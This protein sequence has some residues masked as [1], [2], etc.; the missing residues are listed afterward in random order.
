[1][2]LSFEDPDD[3]FHFSLS[4]DEGMYFLALYLALVNAVKP[5]YSE[6]PVL[7]ARSFL[8]RKETSLSPSTTFSTSS[9][10]FLFSIYLSSLIQSQV[11]QFSILSPVLR[12]LFHVTIQ[13]FQNRR[14]PYHQH[15]G[16]YL[17]CPQDSSMGPVQQAAVYAGIALAVVLGLAIMDLGYR[18]ADRRYVLCSM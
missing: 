1:M 10:P 15:H 4:I 6:S 18:W 8:F 13:P 11:Y 3:L 14:T 16:C 12:R 9:N 17:P 7:R 2:K 5:Y